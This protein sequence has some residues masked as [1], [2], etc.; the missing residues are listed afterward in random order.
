MKWTPLSVR[1]AMRSEKL[2]KWHKWFAWYPVQVT[3]NTTVGGLSVI[4][5]TSVMRALYFESP[6]VGDGRIAPV[7]IMPNNFLFRYMTV[8]AYIAQLLTEGDSK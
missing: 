6:S 1:R 5:L 7:F 8:D 3:D 4:W 2:S